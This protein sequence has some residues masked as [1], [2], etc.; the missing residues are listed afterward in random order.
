LEFGE[1][2]SPLPLPASPP[3]PPG[4]SGQANPEQV[5][6]A[7]V[8]VIDD[9]TLVVASSDLSHYHPYLEARVLDNRCIKAICDLN[10]DEMQSQEACGKLPVLVLM[11]LARLKGWKAK[12]LES[13]NS[14]D[15]SG[16]KNR[17]VGYAAIG[18]Y[19]PAQETFDAAEKRFL[20][21][22][23]RRTL[24]SV[25][26]N[27]AAVPVLNGDD[28]PS[29]LKQ[30]RGCFV[31]LTKSG[32]LRGCIGHIFPREQLYNAVI[33]NA[34]SAATLD[35]RFSAVQ[36]DEVAGLRIEVS[37]LTEPRPLKF[38]SSDEMLGQLRP[39]ED[40]V[41]LQVGRRTATFLPQVWAQIP[42]KV[43]FLNNLSLKAGCEAAAWRGTDTAVLTYQ[44]EA[45]E[46]SE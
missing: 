39:Y 33:Q 10:T 40:G 22:L 7:L 8:A 24:S 46:E 12:L 15:V 34:R 21:E 25:T 9:R 45:F 35:P 11:H 18:F 29:K 44:V 2:K 1:T 3:P 16:D 42:D 23:A 31:T 19:E 13:C 38:K 4:E 26:P 37:V 17:V 36:A 41:V 20:L 32:S 28:I 43:E 6:K 14:G 30:T 5:A 27:G